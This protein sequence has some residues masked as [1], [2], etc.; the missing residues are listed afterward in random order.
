[1]WAS[2]NCLLL[3]KTSFDDAFAINVVNVTEINCVTVEFDDLKISDL[4]FLIWNREKDTLGIDDPDIMKL[5]KVDVA[6]SE[7]YRLEEFKDDENNKIV[8]AE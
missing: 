3:G 2:L 8:G 6:E 5:W 1:M 4:K 7:E